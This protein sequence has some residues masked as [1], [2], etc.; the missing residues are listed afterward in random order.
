MLQA[1]ADGETDPA[2]VAAL[3]DQRWRASPAQLR[4]A[5]GACTALH[6]VYRHLLHVTLLELRILDE[7]IGQLDQEM[8]TLLAEQHEAVQRL[9]EV[10]GLGADSA[11]QVIA[12]VGA[13]DATLAFAQALR[14][15]DGRLPWER[16]ECDVVNCSRSCDRSR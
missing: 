1:L 6:P 8:A 4:D 14:V 13:T 16:G 5:L 11:Q 9:A 15:V 2:T 3:A 12:E 7:Q 10:P